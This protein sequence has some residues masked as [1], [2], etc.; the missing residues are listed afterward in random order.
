[1]AANAVTSDRPRIARWFVLVNSIYSNGSRY[2]ACP[3]EICTCVGS[4]A[5]VNNGEWKQ[6]CKSIQKLEA[7][8]DAANTKK[9]VEKSVRA[10]KAYLKEKGQNEE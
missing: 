10:F 6:V 4:S 1:M 7:G 9:V 5:N 3:L 2:C 8:Q